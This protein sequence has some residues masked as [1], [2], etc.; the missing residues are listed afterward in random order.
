MAGMSQIPPHGAKLK[1]ALAVASLLGL[2]VIGWAGVH[3]ATARSGPRMI[4]VGSS[5]DAGGSV[6]VSPGGRT[7]FAAS[8]D[9]CG[10]TR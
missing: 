10:P 2:V 6:A 7:L 8:G 1:T 9:C 3:V 5:Q 4:N